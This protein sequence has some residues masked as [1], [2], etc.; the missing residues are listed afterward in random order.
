MAIFKCKMCGGT[1]EISE[2]QT[3]AVCDYCGTE[4]TLPKLDD[5]KKANLYDRA[6]HFRRNNEFD[7]AM[8]IYENILNEDSGDAEAYW[9]LVLC[10]Y[11]IEYVEDPATKKRIPTV[12]RAQFTSIYDDDNYKSAIA[13]A[14]LM[15]KAIY[16]SEATAINEIQKG[17]LAI[18]QKEEP[19]DVFICYKET[20]ENGRRT[21]DSVLANELYYQ[22]IA[23]GFKVFFSR[24]TLEDKLG[25]AYE[26]YIFAALNSAKVMVVLGTKPAYFNAVWVKN[27]WSRYLSLVKQSGGKKA[28]IP[29]YRDM[30]PY[31]LPEEFSHLQAQDMSKLGFMQDLIRGIKKILSSSAPKAT[32]KETVVVSGGNVNISPLLKRAFMYLEDGEWDSADEYCEKMLDQDPENGEAY[33]GKL[34]AKVRCRNR[35]KLVN[36]LRPFDDTSNYQKAI[37]FSNK[38]T[39][40]MLEKCTAEIK[41]RIR[42]EGLTYEYNKAL[43]A[44]EKAKR[45][46]H[47]V[48]AAKLF[49]KLGDFA[50]NG[51]VPANEQEKQCH[52]LSKVAQYNAACEAKKNS[53]N[54]SHFVEAAKLFA[55]LGD[56]TPN[57]GV[58][59][60]EQEKQCHYLSKVA[61][62]NAACNAKKNSKNESDYKRAAA[63][64]ADM[65]EFAPEG[66]LPADKQKAECLDLAECSRKDAIL[67]DAKKMSREN[68]LYLSYAYAGVLSQCIT[69]CRELQGWK[70]ADEVIRVCEEKIAKL[71]EDQRIRAEK[72]EEARL[73]EI[74]RKKARK[75]KIK[76]ISLITAIVLLLIAI[77]LGV[78]YYLSPESIYACEVGE[79]SARITALRNESRAVKDGVITIPKKLWGKPV[80]TIAGDALAS[81]TAVTIVIPATVNSF[82]EGVFSGLTSLS[83]V[84]FEDSAEHL[85]DRVGFEK[86]SGYQLQHAGDHLWTEW[87]YLSEYDCAVD[88]DQQRVCKACK[89]VEKQTIPAGTHAI[90]LKGLVEATCIKG[91]YTGDEICTVCNKTLKVGKKTAALGH[92]KVADNAVAAT[93]TK[94]GTTEG[95]HCEVCKKVLVKQNTVAALG[96]SFGDWNVTKAATCKSEGAQKRIC[97]ACGLE[98][99]ETIAISSVHTYGGWQIVTA[100]TCTATGTQ[101]RVCTTCSAEEKQTLYALGHSYGNWAVVK[102]ATCETSGEQKRTCSRCGAEEK[103]TINALGHSYGNWTD[104]VAATCENSGEQKRTC[105]RCGLVEKKAVAALG[106]SYVNMQCT[107][108]LILKTSEGLRYTLVGSTYEVSG[109]GTCKDAHVVIPETYNGKSVTSIG[110]QA[111]YKCG[112]LERVTIPESVT[113]IN[114]CAFYGCTSLSSITIPNSVTN[115]GNLAFYECSS[116]RS[117]N[118]P[119]SVTSIGYSAFSGCTSLVSVTIPNSVTSIDE[120]AFKGCTSL[121]SVT[122]P[123]GVTKIEKSLFKGCIKLS[124]VVIPNGVTRIESYAFKGCSGLLRITIPA[125]VETICY[126]AFNGCN[127]LVSIVFQ[128][129]SNWRKGYGSNNEIDVND[130]Y[131]VKEAFLD[132]SFVDLWKR[133]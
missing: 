16:E 118:I 87:E 30:D 7:K 121:L 132:V 97:S 85:I 64:F 89:A 88:T 49:A 20:D 17:I 29:A 42:I 116:L 96:H 26:P 90:K 41:E 32:V 22:L 53:Q 46:S 18:S 65:A 122:I 126:Q 15:Q 66:E 40:E 80:T 115:I 94:A 55:K 125:S 105:S 37:R 83:A 21:Q 31:D 60:N 38:E 69:I 111:F 109:I 91:G 2:N 19:F 75:K 4:Q 34:M 99:N 73:A 48:E 25:T 84:K 27:E 72:A 61:Q 92:K 95:S 36:C 103:Q 3:T 129:A 1:L 113:S 131:A 63:I 101:K 14:D 78:I 128:D 71:E 133:P 45:P 70:D 110:S 93:C 57:G 104:A 120:G 107:R 82:P 98:E 11:G 62:Y 28:L 6:N 127:S 50:P 13:N 68:P 79:Y 106:H 47:F 39:R 12:N 44:K 76:K 74:E 56:F 114:Y 51:G 33:L 124:S 77:A 100:A 54:P 117:I 86:I 112:N 130:F 81:Q 123:N 43:S 24:I 108:C 67:A 35:D 9:S 23:E 52:Y 58:A 59:A 102:A 8:S 5:E 10:Q 119:N